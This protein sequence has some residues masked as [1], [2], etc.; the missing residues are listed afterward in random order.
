MEKDD[1]LL[2]VHGGFE[3]PHELPALQ[4]T[5]TIMFLISHHVMFADL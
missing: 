2:C 4:G 5:Q 3:V 1:F